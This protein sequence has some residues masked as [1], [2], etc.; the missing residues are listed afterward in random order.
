MQDISQSEYRARKREIIARALSQHGLNI[1]I[2][3]A[4]S[5]PPR[6]RRR[7]ALK[8][9]K[10]GSS[11]A[12]GFSAA[13][14][15]S[16]VDMHECHVLTPGLTALVQ[17]LREMMAALLRGGESIDLGVTETD[18]GF[19]LRL[20]WDRR[21]A[22]SHSGEIARWA[23]RLGIARVT[24]GDDIAAMFSVPSLRVAGAVVHPPPFAFLQPTV[25]GELA[26][27]SRV[28]SALKGATQV[29]DL[30]AGCGTFSLALAPISAVHA[31]EIDGPM[32]AALG[33]AS[34]RTP[35][36][37]PVT[38]ERRN[39]FRR[40][41]TSDELGR[42]DAI[43][44]DPPR[45]GALAQAKLLAQSRVR[46]IA[47]V[48]CDAQSFARDCATLLDGGYATDAVT[49]VDQFIWSEHIELMAVFEKSGRSKAV[50]STT[51]V[52]MRRSSD[53]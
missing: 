11:V 10:V 45:A 44:L 13:A 2:E 47:Y 14:S 22:P 26:L 32:L 21:I 19:D 36:L 15:H 12:I 4:V 30:F 9:T 50:S 1:A 6:T 39:L 43:V 28:A 34:R 31:V 23:Q 46:R 48:S 35:G 25:P 3:E 24:V 20:A 38:T 29:A 17:G 49:P 53:K 8:A 41:L 51:H 42:F 18:T 40:R 16:I 27:Q 52:G 7:A 37:R 5:V 33:E